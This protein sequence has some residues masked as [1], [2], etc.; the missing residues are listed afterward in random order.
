[1]FVMGKHESSGVKEDCVLWY[2]GKIRLLLQTIEK[3]VI[4]NFI[5]CLPET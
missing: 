4:F 1:M 3:T 2:S 5:K